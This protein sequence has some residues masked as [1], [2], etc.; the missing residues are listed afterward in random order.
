MNK[1]RTEEAGAQAGPAYPYYLWQR[2]L[3]LATVVNTAGGSR[4][5]VSRATIAHGLGMSKT[6]S[7]LDQLLAS[8]RAFAM[9]E[10][11]GAFAL[12]ETAKRYFYP[13]DDRESRRSELEMFAS[14]K[15]FQFLITRFD[16]NS[17]PP[18]N[19]LANILMQDAAVGKSWKDRVASIF[20]EAAT[21]LRIIDGGGR[22]RFSSAMIG[23]SE[24]ELLRQAT[25]TEEVPNIAVVPPRPEAAG[26]TNPNATPHIETP[27]PG[28]NV[29]IFSES[30][31]TVK[32]DTPNPLPRALWVRL[33]KY[34]EMLEPSE[35][36]EP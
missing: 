1:Q 7:A 27:T 31:G 9:I 35:G 32:V 25:A 28:R 21:R 8:A 19:T 23:R 20:V 16:G 18:T 6:A 29:W 36:G 11:R 13:R 12:T 4:S 10:G 33:K 22:L 26:S 14:P 30:N 2:S 34:V 3:D 15:V 5:P 17:L 24:E